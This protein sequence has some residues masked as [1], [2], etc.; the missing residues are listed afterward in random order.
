MMNTVLMILSI[1][2][3]GIYIIRKDI[4]VSNI[5][6]KVGLKRIEFETSAK[7]KNDPPSKSDRSN[8]KK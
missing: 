7:E 1:T 3:L 6:F 4:F 8:H 5:K 2:L